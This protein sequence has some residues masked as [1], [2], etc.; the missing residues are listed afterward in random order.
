MKPQ[1]RQPLALA[2]AMAL[3]ALGTAC[4]VDTGLY[5][6]PVSRIA[7]TAGDFDDVSEPLKRQDIPFTV[8][9]G[10]ISSPTWDPSYDHEQVALKVE[11][12]LLDDVE[13]YRYD[14]IFVASGTRGLGSRVYNSLEPDDGIVS[15]PVATENVR[16]FVERGGTLI[17]TDW[18]YDLVE[19]AWPGSLG[20]LKESEGYDGAQ[21]GEPGRLTARISNEA[22]AEALETETLGIEYTYSNWAVLE[23]ASEEVSVLMR[24][25]VQYRVPVVGEDAEAEDLVESLAD[26]PL[27]VA[28]QPEGSEGQVVFSTF[29]I[30][31]QSDGAIDLL[32]ETVVG[33]FEPLPEE[34]VDVD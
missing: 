3:I 26:V 20:F 5:S 15:D 16:D 9:E 2:A 24:G 33:R 1:H 30:D 13:I 31:A 7:T 29:H 18:A 17:V 12:L 28:F 8:Y 14:A 6:D 23:N 22:L 10:I 21:L 11:T 34:Q 19:A 4:K 25:D 32:L 27:M